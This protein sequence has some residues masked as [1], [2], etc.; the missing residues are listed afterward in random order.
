MKGLIL[1]LV[2][3]LSLGAQTPTLAPVDAP[4]RVVVPPN[5]EPGSAI[6]ISGTVYDASGSPLRGASVYV[7]QTDARGYYDPANPRASDTPRLKGYMRTDT[8]GRYEF[9]T[10]RPGSYP[11][12]RNP[13]HIH[14][15]VLAPRHRE[16]VFEIVFEG[17][18]LIPPQWREQAKAEDSGVAIV[19]L[20]GGGSAGPLRGVQ[21]VRLQRQ[22]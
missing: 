2:I 22:P 14:Y 12:T 10:I 15:H 11:G 18:T 7:Y 19:T 3:P 4:S 16:R 13:G 1:A 8:Q 6:V 5:G 21:N 20:S 9:Q 17:D